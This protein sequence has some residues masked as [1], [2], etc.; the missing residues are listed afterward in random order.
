M[1][2]KNRDEVARIIGHLDRAIA[3][4]QKPTTIISFQMSTGQVIPV[5]KDYGSDLTGLFEA[6]R[7]LVRFFDNGLKIKKETAK[8]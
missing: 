3:Y 2:K 7:Q 1:T 5:N 8:C 6:R 4:I